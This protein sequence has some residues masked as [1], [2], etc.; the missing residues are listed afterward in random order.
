MTRLSV[1]THLAGL[2]PKCPISTE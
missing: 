1:K 2:I